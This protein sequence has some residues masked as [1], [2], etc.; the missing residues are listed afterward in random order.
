[1]DFVEK[2]S[3]I[4]KSEHGDLTAEFKALTG[5][6]NPNSVSQLLG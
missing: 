4:V 2:S 1:M 6:E 5:L 3:Q